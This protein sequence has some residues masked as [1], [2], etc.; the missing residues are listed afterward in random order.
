MNIKQINEQFERLIEGYPD[1]SFAD[2]EYEINSSSHGNSQWDP[3]YHM[4][5][6]AGKYAIFSSWFTGG[7]YET[8][9][10]SK[11]FSSEDEAM[12]YYHKKLSTEPYDD[13]NYDDP[14]EDDWLA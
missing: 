2:D 7:E 14:D 1:F 6:V 12:D 13:G 5:E 3:S 11:W 9:K 8:E 10:C 4:I